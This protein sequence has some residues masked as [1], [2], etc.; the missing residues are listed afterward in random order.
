MAKAIID[1]IPKTKREA[2]RDAYRDE[3][4]YWVCLNEG[5]EA[6]RTDSGCRTIHEDTIADLKYQIAGIQ[7]VESPIRDTDGN[8]LTTD[9]VQAIQADMVKAFYEQI[10]GETL[11]AEAPQLPAVVTATAPVPVQTA[12]AV[13]AD[14]DDR[15]LLS[16]FLPTIPWM[17]AWWFVMYAWAGVTVIGRIVELVETVRPHIA[18]GI[19][20]VR[21]WW[22]QSAGFR[23]ELI[24]EY[25]LADWEV[26]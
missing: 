20:F 4:G 15:I 23:A 17:F 2:I 13:T 9:E 8:E 25:R 24:Q 7:R 21:A 6:T 10:T 14:Q 12:K 11:P 18:E 26:A 3:D 19:R 22:K 16:W 5:W 1:Y